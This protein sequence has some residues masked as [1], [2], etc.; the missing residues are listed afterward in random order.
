MTITLP[1]G[2]KWQEVHV[3]SGVG[4]EYMWECRRCEATFYSVTDRGETSTQ[5]VE[6]SILCRR[7]QLEA[8]GS[9][10]SAHLTR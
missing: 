5:F 4:V 8:V 3:D 1:E 10:D 6:G 9:L 2:H 7:K